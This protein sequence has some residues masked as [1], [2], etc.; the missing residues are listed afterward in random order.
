MKLELYFAPGACSFVPHASLEAVKAATGQDFEPKLVKL[1]KGEQ[2]SPEYLAMNPNGQVPV[3]VVDGK[4]LNQIVAILDFLDRSFPKA[5]LL[6]A[7]PWARAQA[8]SQLAWMNNTVHPTFTHIFRK[9]E[10]AESEAA[11]AEVK[12]AAQGRFRKHLERIQAMTAGAKP[13]WFGG[14]ITPHDA[15]AFTLLR[16]GGYAGIDPKSLPGYLAYVERAMAAA[17]MAAA[18][19]RERVK[20]DTYKVS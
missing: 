18:I 19:E 16:W 12:K 4:P 14:H 13:Y 5:A 6:P 7:E 17:P 8:L 1:H 20:L 11:Q 2:K 10:F 3:L 15:Y 9:E